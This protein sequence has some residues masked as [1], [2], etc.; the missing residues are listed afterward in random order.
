MRHK[1]LLFAALSDLIR[2]PVR[3]IVV[4]LCL[5][6]ILLP[7]VS[8]LAISQGLRFQ[9][10]IS[11][12]EGADFYISK[13]LFGGEGPI[14]LT[15]LPKV[16]GLEGI[17]RATARVVGR[18]YFVNRLVAVVGLDR[19]ALLA[20]KL[21]VEGDVPESRGEVLVGQGI[22][23]EFGIHPGPDMRFTLARNNRKVFTPS[24]IL[25]SSSLWSP[26]VM[27]MHYEDANEFFGMKGVVTQLL[28]YTSS[29][30][31]QLSARSITDQMGSR[32][33]RGRS[34]WIGTRK[35]IQEM[36]LKGYD[37]RGGIYTVLFVIGAALAI[38]AFL[39]TS[40]FG[41]K[42]LGREIG[43]LKAM[44][45]RTYE[46]LEKVFLENILISLAAVSISIL[47]SMAWIKGLNGIVIAQFFIA[48]IGVVPD[49]DIPSRYL[50]SHGLFCLV[51]A[52]GVTLSGGLSSAWH[53]TKMLPC[54]L[55]R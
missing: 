40:G 44:G 50:P 52:L 33:S 2:R 35:R 54:E 10:E 11:I 31:A 34:L 24:G 3:S 5:A 46:I 9:A 27:I 55:M 36:L 18:A 26:Y 30:S 37:H 49:V 21:L 1:N 12:Q 6:V 41:L 13:D 47:L 42:E 29:P 17:S 39:V 16:S 38:P 20:L 25:R 22:A 43:V 15:Y 7:L 19:D 53:K 48:E 14:S 23:S 4:T 45:W 51:F 8:A 32:G 28:L